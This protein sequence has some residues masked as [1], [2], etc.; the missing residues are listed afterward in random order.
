MLKPLLSAAIA[1]LMK[2]RTSS[3]LQVLA[4]TGIITFA[5]LLL[6]NILY[7]SSYDRYHAKAD[8]LYRVVSNVNDGDNEYQ[9]NTSQ[10]TLAPELLKRFPE[11]RNAVR[12]SALG[13]IVFKDGNRRFEEEGFYAA[14]ESVFKM[15]SWRLLKGD[16]ATALARPGTMVITEKIARKVF[17][18]VENAYQKVLKTDNGDMYMIRGVMENVP[19]NSHFT[20]DGLVSGSSNR[21]LSGG[22][23]NFS[24]YTYIELP[25]HYNTGR[26]LSHL[27]KVAR[28]NLNPIADQVEMRISYQLQPLTQIHQGCKGPGA[29][30]AG[31]G[32]FMYAIAFML[33]LGAAATLFIKSRTFGQPSELEALH[34]IGM[35][36]STLI[37]QMITESVCITVVAFVV[38]ILIVLATLPLV[39]N[40]LGKTLPISLLWHSSVFITML[41]VFLFAGFVSALYP[42]FY[43]PKMHAL[44]GIGRERLKKEEI[45]IA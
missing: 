24:T 23:G 27:K 38:S 22:W 9:W 20:F 26:M 42:S 29:T 8:H 37:L 45:Y 6:L 39:S 14:D 30:D 31:L 17:G 12:F 10:A 40:I 13:K 21:A 33:V 19:P 35:K 3:L 43:L 16:C 18:S 4:L 11:V 25:E 7:E 15:F 36:R 2:D 34:S 5:L 41:A 44:G 32:D 28:E 1:N